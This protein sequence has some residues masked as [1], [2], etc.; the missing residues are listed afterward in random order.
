MKTI[1]WIPGTNNEYDS[2][3]DDLRDQRHSDTS[4]RLWKNYAKE[5][6]KDVAAL[7]IYFDDNNVPEVCSS[8]IQRP[9]WPKK[10][11]RIHNRAWKPNNKKTFLRKVNPSMG[12]VALSQIEWLKDNTDC[13]LYFISRQTFYWNEWMIKHFKE[14][15][16]DFKTNNYMY[17]TCPNEC[18]STCWQHIIYN[19]N[20]ELLKEWKCRS[21]N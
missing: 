3:F 4:H 17:L 15:G 16:I 21:D 13:E 8:I 18:D 2:L 11:Y 10:V 6:F 12:Y 14:W 19:G 20:T 1:T 9:C 7:S 5:E